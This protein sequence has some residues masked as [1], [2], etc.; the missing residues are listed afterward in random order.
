MIEAFNRGLNRSL[1]VT[2]NVSRTSLLTESFTIT[3]KLITPNTELVSQPGFLGESQQLVDTLNKYSPA[4]LAT[5]M[6]LSD[7]LA[8]LNSTRYE[9]WSPPFTPETLH[10][11]ST[12]CSMYS[13]SINGIKSES[14]FL[15][16][17]E[18]SSRNSLC[19]KPTAQGARWLSSFS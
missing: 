9:S 12:V 1:T 11:L 15:S 16:P 5:L 7:K 19:P 3:V 14:W 6:S 18:A 13:L 17:C 8:V 4:E 10:V 2:I